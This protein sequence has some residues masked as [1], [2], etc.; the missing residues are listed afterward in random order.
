MTD[1]PPQLRPENAEAFELESVARAYRHRPPYPAGVV[2]ALLSL[3]GSDGGAV[4]DAGC[5]TAELGR[6]L[7]ESVD[8][9]D[10]VD[11][12]EAMIAE[13]R[14][15][16]RGDHPNLRW[17]QSRLE[18]ADLRPPYGLAV[19]GD[20]LHW[21][22][23]GVALPRLHDA[24]HPGAWLAIVHRDWGT[25]TEEESELIP[26]YSTLQDY[27]PY[28]LGR[29]LVTRGLFTGAGHLRFAGT[30]HP[31]IE[32]YVEARHSQAGF[33]RDRMGPARAADFDAELTTLLQHLVTAGRVRTRPDDGGDRLVLRVV[34]Q[35]GW[36]RPA[37]STRSAG[38]A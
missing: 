22:E 4:L 34:A 15:Q 32:E 12:S 8:R 7:V 19:A 33:A 18:D 21:M 35:V 20:S 24:L 3:L 27:Q 1:K 36:G 28:D 38:S 13:G 30:W 17:V 29:E 25:G 6:A 31:T 37:G 2:D 5:G 9:V 16:E 26:R 10:A 14:R 11:V 23:W